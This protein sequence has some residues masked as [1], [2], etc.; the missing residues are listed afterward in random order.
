MRRR[1]RTR[2]GSRM[3][4]KVQYLE[5]G[6][7]GGQQRGLRRKGQRDPGNAGGCGVLEAQ[8]PHGPVCLSRPKLLSV[9]V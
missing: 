9:S 5:V 7:R 3:P 4:W 2:R 1:A 6:R 8:C